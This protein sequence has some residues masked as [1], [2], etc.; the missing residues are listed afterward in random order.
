MHPK[1]IHTPQRPGSVP[2]GL[3]ETVPKSRA[4]TL[5]ATVLERTKLITT[6]TATYLCNNEKPPKNHLLAS[7]RRLQKAASCWRKKVHN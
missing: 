2:L 4:V 3:A 1:L 7:E 5:R 6:K